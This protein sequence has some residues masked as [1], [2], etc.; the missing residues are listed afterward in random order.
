M[1]LLYHMLLSSPQKVPTSNMIEQ[2]PK[3][4]ESAWPLSATFFKEVG[5]NKPFFPHKLI[6]L[7]ILL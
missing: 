2:I 4:N 1:G 3:S 7:G 6:V 5:E